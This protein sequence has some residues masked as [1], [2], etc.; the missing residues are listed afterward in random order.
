MDVIGERVKINKLI[1][2]IL[3]VKKKKGKRS[4]RILIGRFSEP[5]ALSLAAKSLCRSVKRD[6]FFVNSEN[7]FVV[8]SN[9]TPRE[10][11]TICARA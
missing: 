4:G 11:N 7:K 6:F 2:N 9:A 10:L 3:N 8:I 5:N 1:N